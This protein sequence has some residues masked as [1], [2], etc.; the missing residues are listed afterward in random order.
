[1]RTRNSFTTFVRAAVAVAC[2]FPAAGCG[3]ELLRTGRAPMYLVVTQVAG[4]ARGEGEETS[5]LQSDVQTLVETTVNGVP[6]KV[7]T[8]FNDNAVVHLRIEQKNTQ[9]PTVPL[10]A[11][12]MT[13]YRVVYRRTDGRN[14]PGTD[15]PHPIEGGLTTT[16]YPD[17]EGSVSFEVVRHQA[18]LEPP[19]KNL[20]G[21][22]G[23]GFISAIAE[24]TLWGRDQNGNDVVAT[25]SLDVH[26][27][28]FGD[29]E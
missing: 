12:T 26:F 25:A 28:D 13:R 1:M 6:I 22:G 18:K 23:L 19:L 15:V 29:E 10:N 5:F 17:T 20:T 14:A 8:V 16:I 27:A 21:F 2:L 7:P 9:F 11:V 4:D 24:I 3:G